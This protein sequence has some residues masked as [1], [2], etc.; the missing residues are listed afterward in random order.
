MN[1]DSTNT[2]VKWVS[3]AMQGSVCSEVGIEETNAGNAFS[4]FPNPA[5]D[6]ISLLS[7]S[8]RT[9]RFAVFDAIGHTVTQGAIGP[10]DALQLRVAEWPPGV[11]QIQWS[12]AEKPAAVSRFVKE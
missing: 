6:N 1:G 3:G 2:V 10:N 7:N 8:S 11:Y 5:S 4:L 12:V 9:A